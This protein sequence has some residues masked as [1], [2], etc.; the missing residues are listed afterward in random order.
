MIRKEDRPATAAELEAMKRL[1]AE[2]MERG[3]LGLSSPQYVPD[4]FAS[5]DELVELARVAAKYGGI[6]ITHQRSEGD[7][8]FKSLERSL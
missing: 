8:L 4:R 6:Y 5:T 1:T 3:A 7:S 2:A